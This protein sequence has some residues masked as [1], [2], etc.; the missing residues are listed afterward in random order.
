MISGGS[1]QMALSDR[2]YFL[3]RLHSVSGIVPL[4]IF[5]AEHLF[6]NSMAVLGPESFNGAVKLLHSLPYLWLIELLFIFLPLA[7]HAI[8]G[9]YLIFGAKNNFLAYNY[10]RN[11]MFYLQRVTAVIMLVFVVWHVLTLRFGEGEIN[12]ATVS[13]Y[14]EHPWVLGAYLVGLF[15]TLF[16]FCNGLSTFLITWGITVGEKSQLTV[17]RAVV[18]LF[19]V[20][21]LAGLNFTLSFV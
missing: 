16:H 2:A 1:D 21:S 7:Y 12:F 17:S 15:S 13:A 11:W 9:L 5:L 20:L 4:G 3:R 8:F 6:T 18:V 10:Y 14:L 19:V